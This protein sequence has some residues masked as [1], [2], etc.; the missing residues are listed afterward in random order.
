MDLCTFTYVS[1]KTSINAGRS[2]C[3]E[4]PIKLHPVES[5][6]ELYPLM[7]NPN[8][9]TD[10]VS[11][12]LETLYDKQYVDPFSVLLTLDT[13]IKSTVHRVDG[14]LK[15]QKRDTKINILVDE[16]TDP[17]AI[18][19]VINLPYIYAVAMTLKKEEQIPETIDYIKKLTSNE[20]THDPRVLELLKPKKTKNKKVNKIE[21]TPRQNQIL[22][23]IQERGCSNKHI[24]KILNL[25]ESTVKLHVGGI[26][27]KYNLKNRTQLALFSKQ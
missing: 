5:I 1:P 2:L 13:L 10:Y 19:Q 16:D 23:L 8:F 25:T 3:E 6:E 9:Y 14:K 15:P 21:L 12:C 18:K 17:D 22:K 4:L 7:S 26:L 20:V 24:A 11:V 27:K